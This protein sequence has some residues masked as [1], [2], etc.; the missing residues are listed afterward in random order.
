MI[1]KILNF[2]KLVPYAG[3]N[4][5]VPRISLSRSQ[6]YGTPTSILSIYQQIIILEI[7]FVKFSKKQPL[8]K[9]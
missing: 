6:P 4:L 5:Q 8:V 1:T 2:A 9:Q 3:T 7:F